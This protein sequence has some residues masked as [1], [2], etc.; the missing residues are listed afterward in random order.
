MAETKKKFVSNGS[1]F[2]SNVDVI[3]AAIDYLH[4]FKDLSKL[5]EDEKAAEAF[6][7]IYIMTAFYISNSTKLLDIY[8]EKNLLQVIYNVNDYFSEICDKLKLQ[9]NDIDARK[10]VNVC[11]LQIRIK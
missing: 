8:E 3:V 9:G 6:H 7:Y 5:S 4:T 11:C 2:S 10:N 1:E